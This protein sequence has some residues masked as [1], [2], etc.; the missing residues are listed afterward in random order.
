AIAMTDIG[1]VGYSCPDRRI[2]DI[3]GLTDRFIARSPGR[4]LEK[5]FDPG[6]VVR[7]NPEYVVIRLIERPDFE[8]RSRIIVAPYTAIDDR[9]YRDPAFVRAYRPGDTNLIGS[10]SSERRLVGLL[11]AARLIPHWGPDGHGY[12]A[13]FRRRDASAE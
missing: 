1:K 13:V 10:E 4:F 7:Q 6:Y 11:R 8:D 9:L 2:L 12:L 3:T 5:D